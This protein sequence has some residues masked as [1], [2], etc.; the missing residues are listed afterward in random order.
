MNRKPTNP[1]IDCAVSDAIE[2]VVTS[3]HTHLTP[4]AY[5]RLLQ[6]AARRAGG[7]YGLRQADVRYITSKLT[8]DLA[9]V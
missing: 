6:R 5:R 7:A 2:I 8:V 9:G 1:Y 4:K 3:D